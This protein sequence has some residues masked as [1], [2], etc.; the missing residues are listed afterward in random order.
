M[1]NTIVQL[2]KYVITFLMIC[3]PCSRLLHSNS[4]MRMSAITF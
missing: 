4:G 1:E 2:S 3:L